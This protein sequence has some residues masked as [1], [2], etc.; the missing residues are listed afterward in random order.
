MEYTIDA[1]N[2]SLGRVAS[3]SAL[4]LRGK[5]SPDFKPNVV[6]DVKLKILNITEIKL[7][8][9]KMKEKTYKRY[10]GYPGGLKDVKFE[11]LFKKN[12]A[13]LF[14]KVVEGMLP[15]NRLRKK[16]LKNLIIEL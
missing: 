5:N 7:T 8:G 3:Q 9:N 13:R 11:V 1:E 2:K 4:I 16:M 14:R 12:P 6:S 10:S 15:K